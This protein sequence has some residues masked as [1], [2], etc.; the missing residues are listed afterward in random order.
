[1]S[2]SANHSKTAAF[3]DVDGT[4]LASTV[5]HYYAYLRERRMARLL[6]P[7]W[8]GAYLLRCLY[9]LWL[10]RGGRRRTAFN[11]YFY[12]IYRGMEADYARGAARPC[13]EDFIK[14]RLFP[15]AIECV[16]DHQAR[17]HAVV[18]VTGSIDF[19][20]QPLAEHLE[21]TH[22]EAPGL[23]EQDGRFTGRLTGP[24]IG[25][26]EKAKRVQAYAEK[27]GIDLSASFA[28]GDSLGDLP[29]LDAVG[30]PRVVNPKKRLARIARERGW[31]TRH[32]N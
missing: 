19:I 21:V 3:F 29:M 30:H 4:L 15:G 28:Y 14:P 18:L 31:E 17:G 22:L 5:V 8:R 1:M 13:F 23:A 32:W 11:E 16:K 24:P 20:M 10:D 25:D 6:R 7:L 12:R 27:T 26:L 2:D 9:F